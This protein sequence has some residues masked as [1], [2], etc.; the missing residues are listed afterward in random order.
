[1]AR[2]PRPR[3]VL[4]VAALVAMTAVAGACASDGPDDPFADAPD[5]RT[6]VTV[7]PPPEEVDL[8]DTRGVVLAPLPG[9]DGPQA[10]VKVYGGDAVLTGEVRGPGGSAGAV[11]RIERF[12]GVRSAVEEVTVADD[13]T[14]RARRL[15][16][17]RY[18]VRAYRS[19][20]LAMLSSAVFFLPDGDEHRLDLE[21]G[22]YGGID[23][24][25]AFL[26]ASLQVGQSATL[27]SLAQEVAVDGSGI[28]RGT[29]LA[30]DTITADGGSGWAIDQ[31][32]R[33]VGA[34]GTTSWTV[35]C[36]RPSPGAITVS[37]AGATATVTP[38]CSAAPPT[39]QPPTDDPEPESVIAV[40]ERFT[41]P[42]AGPIGPGTYDVVESSGTCAFV[43]QPWVGGAW[44]PSRRTASGTGPV[45]LDTFARDLEPL[46][47]STPCTYER[48]S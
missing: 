23:V 26:A 24:Q 5:Q 40:G 22:R 27:T 11:V 14:W 18:R 6:E 9:G 1:M 44:S 48:T 45:V 3:R 46:G 33:A 2:A 43:Y 36:R 16:G 30:G 32:S 35:T 13:G 7:P 41:P 25:A 42:L 21:L 12:V 4:A 17:G 34:D 31:P 15:L 47:G 20:D 19:P 28:V 29:P 10:P 38:P 8:P 39:T 37:V